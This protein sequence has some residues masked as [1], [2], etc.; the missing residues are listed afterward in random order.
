[1]QRVGTI[2]L[3]TLF[4]GVRRR[5]SRAEARLRSTCRRTSTIR[6]RRW[7]TSSLVG[8]RVLNVPQAPE[9]SGRQRAKSSELALRPPRLPEDQHNGKTYDFTVNV[10]YTKF[11]NGQPVTAANFKAAFD[12]DADPRCSRRCRVLL[13]IV[14]S[15]KTLC[16]VSRCREASDHQ[17]DEARRTFC[18]GRDAVLLCCPTNSR[19]TRTASTRRVGRPVLHRRALVNQKSSSSAT[20]TTRERPHNL[21]QVVYT[22]G[23]TLQATYL[24]VQQADGLRRSGIPAPSYAEAARSTA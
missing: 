6:I 18:P 16:R 20:R 12:R 22:I 17:V 21:D 8:A 5:V 13:D 23:N 1:L 2:G 10:P 19:V 3:L 15:D 9:L 11:S 24:R 7:T 14:G 4:R